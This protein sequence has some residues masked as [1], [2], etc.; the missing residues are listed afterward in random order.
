MDHPHFQGHRARHWRTSGVVDVVPW[1]I[2]RTGSPEWWMNPK[3]WSQYLTGATHLEVAEYQTSIQQH[4]TSTIT[5]IPLLY[6]EERLGTL[7]WSV[8]QHRLQISRARMLKSRQDGTYEWRAAGRL[9]EIDRERMMSIKNIMA[10]F[11][12]CWGKHQIWRGSAAPNS[13]QTHGHKI[14]KMKCLSILLHI[15]DSLIS[16]RFDEEINNEGWWCKATI[17]IPTKYLRNPDVLLETSP[18]WWHQSF[19]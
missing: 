16:R 17:E 10:C 7:L 15:R 6:H 12:K 18:A 13:R 5:T 14:R 9:G 3:K 11:M 8:Y 1:L 19:R 2:H 4:F